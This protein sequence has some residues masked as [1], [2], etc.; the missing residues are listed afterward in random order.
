MDGRVLR[1]SLLIHQLVDQAFALLGV[2][3]VQLIAHFALLRLGAMQ[4]SVGSW[5][6]KLVGHLVAN[7]SRLFK[8]VVK[9]P[10][11]GGIEK[12]GNREFLMAALRMALVIQSNRHIIADDAPLCIRQLVKVVPALLYRRA[13]IELVMI[14]VGAGAFEFNNHR[15]RNG[16]AG[17]KKPQRPIGDSRAGHRGILLAVIIV[18]RFAHR[19]VMQDVAKN[20]L[21]ELGIQRCFLLR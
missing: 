5:R 6:T 3:G 9:L 17:D 12:I 21:K 15:R 20:F 13:A 19:L 8:D 2:I 7:Q 10:H 11:A 18:R 1:H 14:Q 4:Q 16:R